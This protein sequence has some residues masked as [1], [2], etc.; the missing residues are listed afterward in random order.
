MGVKRVWSATGVAALTGALLLTTAPTAS[1]DYIRDKQWALEAFD[2]KKVASE[3]EGQGVTVAV[4]DSGVDG[5]HPDLAGQVLDGK[6]FTQ[7]GTD[8]G[9]D[10]NGHGTRMAGIIAGRGHGSDHSAGVMG[11]APKVKIL[12]VRVSQTG[13]GDLDPT[14]WGE[15]IRYAVDHGASVINLSFGDSAGTPGS[16]GAKAIAYAQEHDVVVVASAG[17][18]GIDTIEY[19]AALPGVVAVG[20]VDESLKVSDR[21]NYGSGI[22]LTA[23]GENITSVDPASSSGYSEATGTSDATAFVSAEA[24]LVRSKFPNLTA[25][26]VINRLIKSATFLDNKVEKVPDEKFGYGMIRPYNALTMDIPAGPKE[27]PLAQAAVTPEPNAAPGGSDASAAGKS[28][29]P[30]GGLSPGRIIAIVFGLAAV[31]VIGIVLAVVLR[32]RNR[33]GPGGGTPAPGGYPN[34]P[35]YP[36]PYPGQAPPSGGPNPYG[37]YGQQPPSQGRQ[38]GGDADPYRRQPPYQ[39]H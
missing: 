3:S 2:V 28:A 4:V 14:Q 9:A 26:Q 37:H 22:T 7:G 8:A 10:Q 5:S 31:V 1:A 38:P 25:G 39:G 35:P 29:S 12:P 6:D 33:G 24:A 27:G 17:N 32:R 19:P 11:L 15:G 36:T 21:S 13:K 23:P 34:Q 18:D 20:A 30:A 16:D